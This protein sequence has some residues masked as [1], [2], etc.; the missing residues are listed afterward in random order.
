MVHHSD[1]GGMKREVIKMK[2]GASPGAVE[3]AA[4]LQQG[5]PL[6]SPG[7]WLLDTTSGKGQKG[8]AA[9][10]VLWTVLVPQP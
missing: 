10:H 1:P 2:A 9:D 5:F 8:R 6:V 4:G 7:E 3:V